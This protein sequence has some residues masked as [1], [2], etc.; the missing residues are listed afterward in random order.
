MSMKN[1]NN[2]IRNQTHDLL[3]C[4]AAPQ[5]TAPPHAPAAAAATA[6]AAAVVVVVVVVVVVIVVVVVQFNSIQLVFINL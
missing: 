5:P 1:S 4:S 6:A 2:T 3:A